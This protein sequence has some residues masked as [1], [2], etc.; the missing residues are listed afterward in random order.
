MAKWTMKRRIA[1]SSDPFVA[2]GECYNDDPKHG[3]EALSLYDY[4][5]LR[6]IEDGWE[7][8]AELA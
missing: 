3:V 1:G 2:T 6:E 8:E 7:Y 4:I 5:A